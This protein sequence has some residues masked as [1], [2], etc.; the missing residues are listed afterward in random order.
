MLLGRLIGANTSKKGIS[1]YTPAITRPVNKVLI[2]TDTTRFRDTQEPLDS[3]IDEYLVICPQCGA[4][5]CVVPIDAQQSSLFAPRRVT[6]RTCGYTKDWR[7]QAI[8][9][10]DEHD[11]YF[12]LPLWLQ[13]SVGDKI[14]WAYNLRHLHLIEAFVRASL[15]ERH[16][17]DNTGWRNKSVVSRLPAWIKA[18]KNRKE[19]L[20]A[21]ER[22]KR[23]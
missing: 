12:G 17:D 23:K 16:A 3:F 14:L 15:R 4:C 8:G 6:C 11:S 9:F 5:A 19:I 20:K 1:G 21:I 10:G 22:L 18:A 7:E 2:M 13:I